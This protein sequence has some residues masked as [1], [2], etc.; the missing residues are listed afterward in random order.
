MITQKEFIIKHINAQLGSNSSIINFDK[1]KELTQVISRLEEGGIDKKE[2]EPLSELIVEIS[3]TSNDNDFHK[4]VQKLKDHI[5]SMP[6]KD[7]ILCNDDGG[8]F[9]GDWRISAAEGIFDDYSPLWVDAAFLKHF[10]DTQEQ[11]YAVQDVIGKLV[12]AR[13]R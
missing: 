3:N 4:A 11:Y 6:T 10:E 8:H 7:Y 2:L 5:D 12:K 13:D 9:S 1:V